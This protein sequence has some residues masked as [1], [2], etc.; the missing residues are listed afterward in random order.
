MAERNCHFQ[1]MQAGLHE[2]KGFYGFSLINVFVKPDEQ[3]NACINSVMARKG[4]C[5]E[6][7]LPDSLHLPIAG[8]NMMLFLIFFTIFASKSL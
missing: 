6:T 3:N 5:E 7:N 4:G 1:L 2:E 8:D